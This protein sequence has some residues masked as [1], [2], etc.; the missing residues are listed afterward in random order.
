MSP[1]PVFVDGD[2]VHRICDWHSLVA[3]LEAEHRAPPPRVDRLLMEQPG[4]GGETDAFL[5]WPAW[6]RGEALGIKLVTSFPANPGRR[7]LP[8]VQ[9]VYVLFDGT[10]GRPT[11]V[12]DATAATYWKTAADSALG[13][14]FLAREDSRTLAL[15]GAGALAPWLVAAHRAVRP[16]IARVRVWNRTAVGAEALATRLR[17]EGLDAAAVGHAEAAVREADIV[18]CA[19]SARTP[20]LR[21]AWLRPGTHVDL[22]GSFT[23]EMRESDDETVRRAAIF[24]DSRWFTVGVC[25][26]LVQ[27]VRDG[28]ISAEAVRGDLFDLCGARVPGRRDRGEITL[29][30]NGGGAHLD[31]MTARYIAERTVGTDPA[32]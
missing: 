7:G 6:K 13:A 32:G 12:I 19:T 8:A 15:L 27:P 1:K 28:V 16:A 24:V 30:K 26:D 2:T 17:A 18:V 11:H 10:D 3:H 22:V 21:G 29:F 25:G 14:R 20:I 9:A 5:L 4:E 31:L 23:P